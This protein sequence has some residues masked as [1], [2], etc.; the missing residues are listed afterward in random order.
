[1]LLEKE[2]S[3]FTETLPN[4]FISFGLLARACERLNLGRSNLS[5]FSVSS[6]LF[7]YFYYIIIRT[8]CHH[9][10]SRQGAL[11]LLVL[12]DCLKAFLAFIQLWT[13]REDDIPF[14]DNLF[15]LLYLVW[16]HRKKLVPATT[17]SLC[18]IIY[19]CVFAFLLAHRIVWRAIIKICNEFCPKCIYTPTHTFANNEFCLL[20][21]KPIISVW[22]MYARSNHKIAIILSIIMIIK[23]I[24][25]VASN[26]N[27]TEF[28]ENCFDG[29]GTRH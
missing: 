25:I 11:F 26:F 20:Q 28:W 8:L 6:V 17:A 9:L 22:K 13:Q 29:L 3:Q 7:F 21:L 10:R 4:N 27:W 18:F 2:P 1:M 16:I 23:Y 14:Y 24:I 12:Y 15:S 19:L 5:G